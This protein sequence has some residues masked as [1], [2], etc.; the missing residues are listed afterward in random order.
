M[1][2]YGSSG[3]RTSDLY[4]KEKVVDYCNKQSAELFYASWKTKFENLNIQVSD[5]QL[6]Q[7][8]KFCNDN[9]KTFEQA[10]I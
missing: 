4:G 1:K 10:P 6:D 3:V 9:I 8:Q 2:Y 7:L 5:E